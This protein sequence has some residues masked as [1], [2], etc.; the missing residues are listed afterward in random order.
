MTINRDLVVAMNLGRLERAPALLNHVR[1]HHLA[2]L[3]SL[4]DPE[5]CTVSLALCLLCK[6][7]T[8]FL[9]DVRASDDYAA[10]CGIVA[11]R[12]VPV[13]GRLRHLVLMLEE[14]DERIEIALDVREVRDELPCA[15][16]QQPHREASL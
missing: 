3:M 15:Q 6:P 8:R 13:L 9:K 2:K 11:E 5:S 7:G 10:A 14:V 16:T 12:L 1:A 4:E